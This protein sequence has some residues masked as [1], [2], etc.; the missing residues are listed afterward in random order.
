MCP[1]RTWNSKSLRA[2]RKSTPSFPWHPLSHRSQI[3]A[4]RRAFQPAE[5]GQHVSLEEKTVAPPSPSQRFFFFS[6]SLS[7]SLSLSFLSSP[8]EEL[9]SRSLDSLSHSLEGARGGRSSC[10]RPTR[11]LSAGSLVRCRR[12]WRSVLAPYV[13]ARKGPAPKLWAR[14]SLGALSVGSD[15][16]EAPAATRP[17][18]IADEAIALHAAI[19]HS[20]LSAQKKEERKK[21]TWRLICRI[22]VVGD[23]LAGPTCAIWA[24]KIPRACRF[25][26]RGRPRASPTVYSSPCATAT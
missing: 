16:P 19:A 26:A 23:S 15:A 18:Q 4:E 25:R 10:R 20:L 13:V 22:S 7:L 3:K 6:L 5:R 14:Y 11:Y 21:T 1:A 12:V 24:A 2:R 17:A 8:Q 9:N